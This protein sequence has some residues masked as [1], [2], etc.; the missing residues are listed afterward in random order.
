MLDEFHTAQAALRGPGVLPWWQTINLTDEQHTK[1]DAAL[2]DPSIT[3]RAISVVLH[4]W[5][6]EVNPRKVGDYRRR[7]HG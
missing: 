2:R 4:Q 7:L 6:H 5:G 3:S 1:L